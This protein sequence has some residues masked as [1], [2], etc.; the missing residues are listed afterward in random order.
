M[1]IAYG[2]TKVKKRRSEIEEKRKKNDVIFKGI[3]FSVALIADE[4]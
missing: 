1:S 3:D 2:V 4:L